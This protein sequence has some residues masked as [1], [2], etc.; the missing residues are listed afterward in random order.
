MQVNDDMTT[1]ENKSKNEKS[2]TA[3]TNDN[4]NTSKDTAATISKINNE[5]KDNKSKSAY[6]LSARLK[7][8]NREVEQLGINPDDILEE[9]EKRQPLCKEE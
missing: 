8:K 9:E 7:Q 5:E 4:S 6:D 1:N 2:T 3:T